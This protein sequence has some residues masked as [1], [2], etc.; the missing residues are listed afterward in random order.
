VS[1]LLPAAKYSPL[2]FLQ[3]IISDKKKHLKVEEA[4]CPESA[5]T[6]YDEFAP[7]NLREFII[8]DEELMLYLPDNIKAE[9]FSFAD[10]V[11]FWTVMFH[12]RGEWSRDYYNKVLDHHHRSKIIVKKPLITV[13]ED[14]LQKLQAFDFQS[15]SKY[16]PN[17]YRC[18]QGKQERHLCSH[19]EGAESSKTSLVKEE[20]LHG[21]LSTPT[22]RTFG[23]HSYPVSDSIRETSRSESHKSHQLR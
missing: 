18:S 23:Y 7:R 10:R 4:K 1:I 19:Q 9:K 3:D 15:K 13:S 5:V 16:H 11:F 22:N 8:A 6:K 14:W 20:K 12:V 2:S 17:L 21:V